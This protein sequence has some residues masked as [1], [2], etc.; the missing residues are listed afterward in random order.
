MG[1][2]LKDDGRGMPPPSGWGGEGV[3][4]LEVRGLTVAYGPLVALDQVCL[5]VAAGELVGLVGPNGSGKSTLIRAV[6]RVV[7]CLAGQV[8][9]LGDDIWRLAPRE[10]ARRVAVVPQTPALP[11]AFAS[12]AVV[13]LGRTPHLGLLRGEG[14]G[15]LEAARRAMEATDTWRL[16]GRPVGELSGGERQRVILARAL[17]Q[18]TPL[19]LLDE[20]TAHLD[21]GHQAA[22]LARMLGLCRQGKGVLAA[23]HDLT[24]AGQFCH[25][26]VML[27]GGRVVASG[28]PAQVLTEELLARVYGAH[29]RILAH[30][31]TGRP[32]VVPEP[33]PSAIMASTG[34]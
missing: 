19:L 15:D 14:P 30:P 6:T 17:A 33:K 4:L 27:D 13:L 31:L 1:R 24:L 11:E 7:P 9:L 29:V 22:T 28:E 8:R 10:I 12:L 5:S 16:A 26:L 25:R 34:L 18:Q 3:P 20:P 32:V 21:I 23:I 2:R